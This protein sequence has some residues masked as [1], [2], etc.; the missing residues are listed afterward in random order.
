MATLIQFCNRC[1]ERKYQK[2]CKKCTQYLCSDCK[3]DHICEVSSG[4]ST[5]YS[6]SEHLK[7]DTDNKPYQCR[8]HLKEAIR[9][10]FTCTNQLCEE[11][12]DTVETEHNGHVIYNIENAAK[13]IR[14]Q[15]ETNIA[16][17]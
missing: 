14:K 7:K 6:F 8:T 17:L 16:S 5:L 12:L 3:R 2:M 9:F 11:C 1:E 10:C 13:E 4:P 15:T